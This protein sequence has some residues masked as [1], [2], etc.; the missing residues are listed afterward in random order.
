MTH[1]SIGLGEDGPTH[2]PIEQLAS[3]R[4]IPN[5]TVIRPAD[6]NETAEAWRQAVTTNNGPTLLTLSRQSLPCLDR[7]TYG[8]ADGLAKG[9]YILKDSD[10]ETPDAILLASGSEVHIA[11]TAAADLAGAGIDARVVSMPSW[12]LFEAQPE[13]YRQSVLPPEIT[14]R[15]AIEAGSTQ[16]WSRYTGDRGTVIGLD[17]FGASAPIQELYTRFGLTA[18]RIVET[19]TGLL[20]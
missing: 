17:H 8:P 19:V 18:E 16:G 6:A 20:K 15:V 7:A 10:N 12:E 5:L 2:Q 3:L 14:A 11:L 13:S 4:A 9:A 1:D